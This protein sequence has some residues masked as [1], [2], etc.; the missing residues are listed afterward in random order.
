MSKIESETFYTHKYR[1]IYENSSIPTD[2]II[3]RYD[4]RAK[5]RFEFLTEHLPF[6]LSSKI[7]VLEIGCNAGNFLHLFQKKGCVSEGVESNYE[8]SRYGREKYGLAI[9][10][11][12]FEKANLQ[13]QE[14][15]LICI[16]HVIEHFRDPK[17]VLLR[18]NSLLG[19]RGMLF[20][21]I[22]DI[23]AALQRKIF[24]DTY[25]HDAHLYD[26]SEKTICLM[27]E[28]TGFRIMYLDHDEPQ[29]PFDKNMRIFASRFH[30]M[31]GAFDPNYWQEIVS[32]I[33]M[34]RH[35][36]YIQKLIQKIISLYV[37]GKQ[38]LKQ[39]LGRQ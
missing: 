36:S 34:K 26:F 4:E 6:P 13:F 27:L 21:E 3:E 39:L 14:Y 33:K 7:K 22:P 15:D 35:Q 23:A 5:K 12:L 17:S 25:F 29:P 10:T 18:V 24:Q 19:Q 31:P 32:K 28:L 2:K 9:H 38:Y 16:V 8:Y 30:S 1:K 20:L 37:M 11:A